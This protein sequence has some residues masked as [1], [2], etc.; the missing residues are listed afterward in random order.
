MS[1]ENTK[2][3]IDQLQ[4]YSLFLAT[5][6]YGGQ[7]TGTYT[8]AVTELSM[9]CAVNGIKIKHYFLFNESLIQ[10]AR[11]YCVDEFMRSDCTHLLFIDADVS[12]NPKDVLTMLAIQISNPEKYDIVSGAYPKKTIA[13]EKVVTAVRNGRADNSPFDLDQF[14]GDFTFNPIQNG[15]Q[16]K[17]SVRDPIE[18]AEAATGFMLI[19]RYAL[20]KYRDEY[21]ELSYKPDHARTENFDGTREITAFFDCGIDPETKRYLSED[22]FFSHKA[23]AIGL[24]LWMCPWINLNHMGSY[25]FKGNL[26][27]VSSLPNTSATASKESMKSYYQQ[28]DDLTGIKA[29]PL[30]SNLRNQKKRNRKNRKK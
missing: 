4:P 11:N 3:T 22:Y 17:F 7:C 12:F 13:W 20:E 9:M 5:P 25:V 19:P 1:E 15:E 14:I 26:P 29:D 6:M 16:Q 28:K 10:R 23:R 21:P 8:K 18:V 2:I 24:N 27:A 30:P